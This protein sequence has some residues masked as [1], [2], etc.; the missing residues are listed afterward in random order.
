VY[1]DFAYG[2]MYQLS[3]VNLEAAAWANRTELELPSAT[4]TSTSSSSSS[5]N[6]ARRHCRVIRKLAGTQDGK[7]VLAVCSDG[8]VLYHRHSSSGCNSHLQA[9]NTMMIREVRP[10][11]SDAYCPITRDAICRACCGV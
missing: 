7:H 8:Q 5:I 4:V 2:G 9:L 3:L 11:T 1:G 10:I 6:N